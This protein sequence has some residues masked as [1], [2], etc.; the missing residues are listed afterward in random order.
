MLKYHFVFLCMSVNGDENQ[1]TDN[2]STVLATGRM[3]LPHASRH[4]RQRETEGGQSVVERKPL[5]KLKDRGLTLDTR[6]PPADKTIWCRYI[7]SQAPCSTGMN[8]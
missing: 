7:L 5:E 3:C 1:G 2:P 4:P 8:K 6:L